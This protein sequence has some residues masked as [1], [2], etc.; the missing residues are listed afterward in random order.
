[1]EFAGAHDNRT[2]AVACALRTETLPGNTAPV[3][4]LMPQRGHHRTALQAL[5][6][7]SAQRL[8]GHNKLPD[9]LLERLRWRAAA[10]S[11]V[12]AARHATPARS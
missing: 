5:D 12:R 1:L 4:G 8:D 2:V 3:P 9:G 11:P 7:L 6:S 10:T